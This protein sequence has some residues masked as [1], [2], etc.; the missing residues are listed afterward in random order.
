MSIRA[1]NEIEKVQLVL[2][3]P[4]RPDTYTASFTGWPKPL[5]RYARQGIFQLAEIAVSRELFA[6]I[7]RCLIRLRQP[8]RP[9]TDIAKF[10][11]W[12][13]PLGIL[14]VGTYIKQNNPGVEVEILDGNNVLTLDEVKNRIDADLVGI[15]ATAL[16]Y[17]HAI[18]VAK[19][20]K[21]RGARVILGGATM[22][23]S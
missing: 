16:G 13:Q 23:W 7:L 15:S 3:P 10:A 4:R 22:A 5:A 1:L 2:P 14:S 8:S 6:A 18:E 21:K 20:A 17:D 12:P 9:N 19:V 11:R